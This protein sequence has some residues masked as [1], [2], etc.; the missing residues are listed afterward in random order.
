MC[1]SWSRRNTS[2]TNLLFPEKLLT[3]KLCKKLAFS[4]FAL[5][6]VKLRNAWSWEMHGP[7]LLVFPRN[8]ILKRHFSIC[9]PEYFYTQGIDLKMLISVLTPKINHSWFQKKNRTNDSFGYLKCSNPNKSP[10]NADTN[11]E[12]TRLK[13]RLFSNTVSPTQFKQWCV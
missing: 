12:S 9:L 3:T 6:N 1:S 7:Q 4:P 5:S 13:T 2:S 10:S 11:F 8:K